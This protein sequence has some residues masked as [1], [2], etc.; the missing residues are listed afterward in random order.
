MR[1]PLVC[2]GL[3]AGCATAPAPAPDATPVALELQRAALDAKAEEAGYAAEAVTAD[4]ETGPACDP[5]DAG[6]QFGVRLQ[7]SHSIPHYSI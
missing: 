2:C 4:S 5:A 1:L 3:L 7:M 6:G